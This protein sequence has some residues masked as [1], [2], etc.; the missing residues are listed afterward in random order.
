M[1][2]WQTDILERAIVECTD[3]SGMIEK[4]SV[5]SLQPNEE[6]PSCAFTPPDVLANE[7]CAGPRDGLCGNITIWQ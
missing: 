4:C 1:N 3:M 7:D 5:F 2:G 6:N